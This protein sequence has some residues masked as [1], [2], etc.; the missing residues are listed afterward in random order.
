[1]LEEAQSSRGGAEEEAGHQLEDKAAGQPSMTAGRC[2]GPG[3]AG[4]LLGLGT[5]SGGRGKSVD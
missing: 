5:G 3:L 2:G 4:R 1:M